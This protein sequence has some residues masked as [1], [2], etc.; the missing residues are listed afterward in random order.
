MGKDI[1]NEAPSRE[2]RANDNAPIDASVN[3]KMNPTDVLYGFVFWLS[4]CPN[5]VFEIG[6][7]NPQGHIHE[8]LAKFCEENN[9]PPLTD[10]WQEKTK[11]PSHYF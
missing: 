4:E 10:N 8:A 2:E 11:K 5:R 1:T 9:L 3:P 7:A 6:A